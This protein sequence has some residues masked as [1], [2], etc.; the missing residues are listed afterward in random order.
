MWYAAKF[1]VRPC[2]VGFLSIR[3]HSTVSK[4]SQNLPPRC[5]NYWLLVEW[6]LSLIPQCLLLILADCATYTK[7][8]A[9]IRLHCFSMKEKTCL[10]WFGSEWGATHWFVDSLSSSA[11][12]W[13]WRIARNYIMN[14]RASL[15][16]VIEFQVRSSFLMRPIGLFLGI[17]P[18]AHSMCVLPSIIYCR[19]SLYAE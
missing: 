3:H 6:A 8:F 12:T 17:S 9:T 5:A 13:L 10:L 7:E 2:A 14:E 1:Q 11:E 15:Y 16:F 4:M 18:G 19:R